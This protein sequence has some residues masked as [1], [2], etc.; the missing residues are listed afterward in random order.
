MIEAFLVSDDADV[1]QATEEYE[2]AEA[3][4]VFFCRRSH[5]GPVGSRRAA[6]KVNS[7][8]IKGAP[9]QPGTI[10]GVRTGSVVAIGRTEMRFE[11]GQQKSLELHL[12]RARI[13]RRRRLF[14]FLTVNRIVNR[15][16]LG[17]SFEYAARWYRQS[18]TTVRVN[19]LGGYRRSKGERK[20]NN[21]QARE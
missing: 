3:K 14:D 7:D 8:V 18:R 13:H 21:Q 1:R 11:R 19:R 5:C 2:V 12:R 16:I 6:L 4:L 10:K 17:F 20:T 15:R 9:H